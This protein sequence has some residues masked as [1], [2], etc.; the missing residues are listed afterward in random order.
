MDPSWPRRYVS[1][2]CPP[3][4]RQARGL[5]PAPPPRRVRRSCHTPLVSSRSRLGCC[6][7]PCN[8]PAVPLSR[9]VQRNR[10]QACSP[11]LLRPRRRL[12]A[13]SPQV[14][15]QCNQLRLRGAATPQPE[16][17]LWNRESTPSPKSHFGHGSSLPDRWLVVECVRRCE[18][19]Q[20]QRLVRGDACGVGA[21][22]GEALRASRAGIVRCPLPRRHLMVSA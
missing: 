4:H 21:A 17:E 3:T 19:S 9:D 14:V 16:Y 15:P 2:G 1:T 11:E 8:K 18:G 12:A 5:E 22:G 20:I 13:T 7:P 6:Q 10:R